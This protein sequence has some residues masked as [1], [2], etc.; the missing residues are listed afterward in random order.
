[1]T[2]DQGDCAG[3]PAERAFSLPCPID[4]ATISTIHRPYSHRSPEEAPVRSIP[5]LILLGSL[6]AIALPVRGA[7]EEKAGPKDNMPPD[8]F[9][10]LFNGKDL[11]GW[12]GLVELPQR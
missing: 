2:E 9:T 4:R 12:Q 7:D 8:G 11:S 5:A 6:L 3:T 10:A 1:M